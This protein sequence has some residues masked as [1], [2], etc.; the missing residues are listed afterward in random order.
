MPRTLINVPQSVP[1][2]T[3]FE[4]KTLVSHPMETGF[5]PD[6]SGR[7]RPRD[8]IHTFVCTYNGEEVFRAELFPA[9]AAN[10][11]LSFTAVATESGELAFHWTDDHGAIHTETARIT[12]T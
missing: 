7:L 6:E 2:G 5:R 3:V 10:P 11:F 9:I 8:I 4:I 12:V 1:R